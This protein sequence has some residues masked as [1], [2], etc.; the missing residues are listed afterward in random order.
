MK[1]KLKLKRSLKKNRTL[2]GGIAIGFITLVL[3]WLL[4]IALPGQ[5]DEPEPVAGEAPGIPLPSTTPGDVPPSTGP[6]ISARL[7]YVA[8][9]GTSLSAVERDVPLAGSPAAQ[10]RAILDAQLAPAASPLVSAVP[11][12][13]TLRAVFLTGSDAYVDLSPEAIA[14]HPGG[15][16]AESLTVYSIVH[17]LTANLPAIAAVQIL[18]D[19]KEVDTLAGH[20]NLRRP[21]AP[22]PEWNNQR[23]E[24]RDQRPAVP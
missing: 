3:A 12:G 13:T 23:S 20:L 15:S 5:Y 10:A 11:A 7:F 18:V 21:L 16:T 6:R 14:A 1:V 22:H 17:A 4:F 2:A 19:G 8:E 24:T 9:D